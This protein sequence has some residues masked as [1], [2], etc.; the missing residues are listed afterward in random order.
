[1]SRD[2]FLGVNDLQGSE[3]KVQGYCLSSA[4]SYGKETGHEMETE[5]MYR[6]QF[7][8]LTPI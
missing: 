4:E 7:M 6:L 8:G 2:E 3:I 1:M 5:I